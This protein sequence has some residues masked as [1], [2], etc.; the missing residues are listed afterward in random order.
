[1]PQFRMDNAALNLQVLRDDARRD[2]LELMEECRGTKYLVLD[3]I[4]GNLLSHILT[5]ATALFKE[6]G[7]AQV[8]DLGAP[9]PPQEPSPDHM[10]AFVLSHVLPRFRQPL[11][12]FF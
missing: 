1:M 4:V 7:V 3:S 2:F 8:V 6:K 12:S 9:P 11:R 10:S 5:D